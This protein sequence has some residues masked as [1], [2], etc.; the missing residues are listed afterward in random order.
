MPSSPERADRPLNV[1]MVSA[2][3][4]PFTGGTE[5]HVHEVGTR[6]A[7]AGHAVTVL[8]ADQIGRVSL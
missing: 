7:A 6:L 5:T 8:T 1:L 2:R 3:Y 4:L